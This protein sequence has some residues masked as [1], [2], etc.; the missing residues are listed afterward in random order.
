MLNEELDR[1]K[2]LM[3][4]DEQ[5]DGGADV[6]PEPAA[7]APSSGGGDTGGGG[8]GYPTVTKWD[9]G[10]KRGKANP[11]GNTKWDLGLTR[12]KGNQLGVTK[13]ESGVS[14]GKANTL[15]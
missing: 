15:L 6:A 11:V 1:I 5:E 7:S 4:I 2:T 14:R 9:S 13:W 8:Q 3:G 12:G 10:V